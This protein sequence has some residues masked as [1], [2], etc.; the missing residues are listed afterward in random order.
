MHSR[1]ELVTIS[2]QRLALPVTQGVT[3]LSM[4]IDERVLQVKEALGWHGSLYMLKAQLSRLVQVAQRP[5]LSK[6]QTRSNNFV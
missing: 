2:G 3:D 6:A 4:D 1:E 5:E